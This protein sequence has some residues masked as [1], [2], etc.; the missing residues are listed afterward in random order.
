MKFNVKHDAVTQRF[1]ASIAGKDCI[2]KYEIISETIWDF[3][4]LFV[5]A[6]LRGQGIAAKVVE[7]A[8]N[9]ARKNFIRVKPSCSYVK[10]FVKENDKY[11]DVLLK[12]E[13][14]AA[15]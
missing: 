2:L 1:F 8:L 14:T 11:K 3:R 12:S 7:Y 5:P 6:N 9:Y 15:V 10:D 13:H 4:M